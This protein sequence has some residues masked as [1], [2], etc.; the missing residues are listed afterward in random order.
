MNISYKIKPEYIHPSSKINPLAV[1][2]VSLGSEFTTGEKLD[3]ILDWTCRRF[4][5]VIIILADSLYR[6]NFLA[7]SGDKA[8]AYNK[9]LQLGNEWL[10]KNQDIFR[11]H[12][13][14]LE[15]IDRWD[16]WLK[17]KN[18]P[19]VYQKVCNFYR[20]NEEFNQV[21]RRDSMNFVK[22]GNSDDKPEEVQ[23]KLDNSCQ[24]L[25]E[26]ASADICFARTEKAVHIYPGSL[27]ESIEFLRKGDIP[28]DLK[29][30]EN[31]PEIRVRFKRKKHQLELNRDLCLV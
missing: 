7:E 20:D 3:L 15:R 8:S 13:T 23:L 26:E 6:H 31:F 19:H 25:L 30:L 12:R 27:P 4:E 10:E 22:R 9:S 18:F 17:N 29:G 16:D 1:I 21:I 14:K 28:N 2:G 5:K 24:F 11:N